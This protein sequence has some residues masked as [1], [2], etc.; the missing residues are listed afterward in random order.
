MSVGSV[1]AGGSQ[2]DVAD[3][4]A[5]EIDPLYAAVE[6]LGPGD[7][8]FAK[9]ARKYCSPFTRLI[10][11]FASCVQKDDLGTHTMYIALDTLP[12]FVLMKAFLGGL[13]RSYRATRGNISMRTST[14]LALIERIPSF[15]FSFSMRTAARLFC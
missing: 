11:R 14:E 12:F 10:Y 9:F 4:S 3:A 7:M 8:V 13:Q 5:D 15:G 2:P 1:D 6:K